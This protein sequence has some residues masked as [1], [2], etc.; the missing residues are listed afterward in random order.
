M[1]LRQIRHRDHV[2]ATRE[3][4]PFG[5]GIL[6]EK[7][8]HAGTHLRRRG[9]RMWV[10]HLV[11][12]GRGRFSGERGV[13]PITAGCV[14]VHTPV[15]PFA[16]TISHPLQVLA[17]AFVGH[18]ARQHF[19]RLAGTTADCW[20]PERFARCRELWQACWTA[21]DEA[22]GAEFVHHLCQ[23]MVVAARR[24]RRDEER[25]EDTLIERAR[26]AFE[27]GA[28]RGA[29]VAG[30]ADRLGVSYEHLSRRFRQR[31][32]CSPQTYCQRL[33][34]Q[35][36]EHLLDEGELSLAA[37][38]AAVGYADYPAFS[39]AFRRWTGTCPSAWRRRD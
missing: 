1:P 26:R 20:S 3:D 5:P 25:E 30:V 33:R 35:R 17:V 38:A 10:W 29:S 36:A 37:I 21:A 4:G 11:L 9:S 39:Q 18:D 28:C 27:A 22:D 15:A 19:P 16:Y 24:E 34:R 13:R 2:F 14:F 23:A 12:A 8:I 32:G 6:V 7:T 31:L